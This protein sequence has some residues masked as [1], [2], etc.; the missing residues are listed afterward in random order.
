MFTIC[1]EDR[2]GAGQELDRL[3]TAYAVFGKVREAIDYYEQA[4]AITRELGDQEELA[5]T[6]WNLGLVLEAQGDLARAASLMQVLV[7]YE[8]AAEYP[9]VAQL[10]PR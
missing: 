5:W 3:G 4:L 7:D 1:I 8:Q 2:G 10:R 6:S 9:A